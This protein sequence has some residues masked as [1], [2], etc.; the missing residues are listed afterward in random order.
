VESRIRALGHPVHPMLVTFP[1]GLWTAAVVFDL[2]QLT[3]G[4][5]VFGEVAYWNIVAGSIGAVLAA[6]TGLV[7]WTGIPANTRAKRV[8][9]LHAGLNTLALLLFVVAWLVRMDNPRHEVSGGLFVVE[10]LAIVAATISAWLGGELVDRLGIGVHEDAHPDASSSL[11]I[12]ANS[13][14]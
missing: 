11:R 6:V 12:G 9:L 5:E 2:I 3:S 8:G 10:I 1:I 13:R 14:G 4:N 7:D